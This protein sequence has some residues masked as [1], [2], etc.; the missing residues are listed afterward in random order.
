MDFQEVGGRSSAVVTK[1]LGFNRAGS[2]GQKR[3]LGLGIT[4]NKADGLRFSGS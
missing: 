4:K 1:G 3:R 2:M